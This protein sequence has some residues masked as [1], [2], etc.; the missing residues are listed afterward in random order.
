MCR[1]GSTPNAD[2]I[3]GNASE[4]LAR[5]QGMEF[6][7]E[8]SN[9]LLMEHI[10]AMKELVSTLRLINSSINNLASKLDLKTSK[11]T[12]SRKPQNALRKTFS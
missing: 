11:R 4:T 2:D 10:S 7:Q 3:E 9:N 5:I 1:Q 8:F 12:R 6:Q